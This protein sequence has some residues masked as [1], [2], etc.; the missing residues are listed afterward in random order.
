MEFL[1][2]YENSITQVDANYKDMSVDS[3]SIQDGHMQTFDAVELDTT[4]VRVLQQTTT[5][6]NVS[7]VS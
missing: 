1:R 3:A 4:G 7:Q 5:A 2:D 6:D